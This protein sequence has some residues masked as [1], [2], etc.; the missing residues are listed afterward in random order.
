ML[1]DVVRLLHIL[2]MALWLGAALWVPGDV[3][4]TLASGGDAA[5]LRARARPAVLLDLL[6]GIATVITGLVLAGL[7]GPMRTGL[8]IGAGVGLVLLLVALAAQWPA[9]QRIAALL[10]ANDLAGARA[11]AGRL[12]ALSGV[13]H[14]LWLVALVLM[15]LPV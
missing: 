9:W 4:R 10:E 2:S 14:V 7:L 15:V 13:A 8:V 5:A 3:R 1:Y 6:A 11:A 12:A